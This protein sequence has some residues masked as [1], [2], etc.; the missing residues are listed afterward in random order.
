MTCMAALE[1]MLP[2]ARWPHELVVWYPERACARIADDE[3]ALCFE[4]KDL[5]TV[6]GI[7]AG[8][9]RSVEEP[10]QLGMEYHSI[11]ANVGIVLLGSRSDDCGRA[12]GCAHIALSEARN[13]KAECCFSIEGNG[14]AYP[15]ESIPRKGFPNG[16]E[17]RG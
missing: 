15:E 16:V 14:R 13:T 4:H 11:G 10:V 3:F 6:R 2:S 5:E 1:V 9:V 12:P 17:P 7:A 8:L